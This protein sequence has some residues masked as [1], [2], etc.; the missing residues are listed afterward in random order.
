MDALLAQLVLA[1]AA[2]YF[3][4]AIPSAY[5]AGRF[6]KNLDIRLLGDGNVGAENAYAELGPK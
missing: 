6:L 1:V 3:L 2:G 5:L 4:G